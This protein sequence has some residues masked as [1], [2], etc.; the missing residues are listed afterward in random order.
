MPPDF[1]LHKL[2]RPRRGTAVVEII[3]SAVEIQ[4]LLKIPS[5]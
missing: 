1:H 3:I 4:E 2:D 5:F